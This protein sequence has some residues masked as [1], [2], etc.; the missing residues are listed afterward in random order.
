MA[1][2]IEIKTPFKSKITYGILLIISLTL[3]ISGQQT[4]IDSPK[5]STV[6][7]TVPV[8]KQELKQKVEEMK[9]DIVENQPEITDLVN[10]VPVKTKV[11]VKWRVRRDTVKICECPPTD[12]DYDESFLIPI[13]IHDTI[14]IIIHDTV[15]K[16][17]RNILKRIFKPKKH[18]R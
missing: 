2:F 11:I 7:P 3:S 13:V 16:E 1:R 17:K 6:I 15:Y 5:S 8:T 4:N 12:E 18:K 9:K 14:P 10:K